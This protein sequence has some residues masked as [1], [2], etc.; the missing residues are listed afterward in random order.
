MSFKRHSEKPDAPTQ[1]IVDE[2]RALG[3]VV[4]HIGRPVDLAISHPSWLPNTWRLVEVKRPA[5]K[6]GSPRLDKRQKAQAAFVAAHGIPY[7]TSTKQLIEALGAAQCR[8]PDDFDVVP[9]W[10]SA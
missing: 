6:R 2:M 1:K 10:R 9:T 5:N 3:F 8:L 7:V 4:E